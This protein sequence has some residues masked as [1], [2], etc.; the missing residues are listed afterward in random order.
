MKTL[1]VNSFQL[2]SWKRDVLKNIR[3]YMCL[4]VYLHFLKNLKVTVPV[5]I[6]VSLNPVFTLYMHIY[7]KEKS[8]SAQRVSIVL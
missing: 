1:L 7:S 3:T 4:R 8:T 6:L 5:Y 2:F